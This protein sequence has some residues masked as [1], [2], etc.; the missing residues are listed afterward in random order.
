MSGDRPGKRLRQTGKGG[1]YSFLAL[2][3]DLLQSPEFFDL[4]GSAI[5]LLLFLAAQ[6]KGKNN[7]NLHLGKLEL[8]KAGWRSEATAL[9]ARQELLDARFIVQTRHGT[10]RRCHLYALTWLPIDECP[11]S[12]LEMAPERVPSNSWK[13]D[14][15]HQK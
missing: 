5:K 12:G 7:G 8:F 6:F 1:D 2:R 15:G 3:H 4:S 11:R 14:R 10:T 9:R 13:T